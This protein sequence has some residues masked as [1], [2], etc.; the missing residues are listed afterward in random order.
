MKGSSLLLQCPCRFWLSLSC[1]LAALGSCE[2]QK[3]TGLETAVPGGLSL[4]LLV[5][6]PQK[7]AVFRGL[8][9]DKPSRQ[10]P[11][12]GRQHPGVLSQCFLW[13]LPVNLHKQ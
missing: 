3:T 8:S 13:S 2:L 11:E 7:L 4:L 1:G 12:S 6:K 5:W 10:L 9:E